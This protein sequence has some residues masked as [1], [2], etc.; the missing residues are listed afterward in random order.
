MRS[1]GY[2]VEEEEE[3]IEGARKAGRRNRRSGVVEDVRR[4]VSCSCAAA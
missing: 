3:E 2:E 1:V 4:S